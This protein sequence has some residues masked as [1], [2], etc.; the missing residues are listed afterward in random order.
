VERLKTTE[1]DGFKFLDVWRHSIDTLK[2][3]ESVFE[4]LDEFFPLFRRDL[5]IYLDEV[6]AGGR[7]RRAVLKFGA[8]MHDLGKPEAFT[9]TDGGNIHFFSHEKVSARKAEAIC[10]RLKL[11]RKEIE[12][13]VRL[14][15]N[16]MRPGYLAQA[17]QVTERAIFK[18]FRSTGRDG[19]GVVLLSLA[20]RFS[21][22]GE[23]V[24]KIPI[25]KYLE[26]SNS[27]LEAYFGPKSRIH[28][29][30]FVNGSDLI[31]RFGLE[32]GPQIGDLLSRIEVATF[33]GKIRSKRDALEFVSEALR[34]RKEEDSGH[35]F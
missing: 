11:S 3:L 24:R 25:E 9:T 5:N 22:H 20:D 26:V 16:H 30:R 8:V 28:L 4:R 23:K 12:L 6:I 14:I 1:A 33:E 18:F 17:K 10:R 34:H 29:K 27:I 35:P 21:A 15:L 2:S 13:M 31:R 19:I 7:Q 32:P